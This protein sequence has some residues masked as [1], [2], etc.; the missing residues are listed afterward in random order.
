MRYL[1]EGIVFLGLISIAVG[2]V[3]VVILR[4]ARNLWRRRR[5][6]QRSNDP[7]VVREHSDGMNTELWLEHPIEKAIYIDEVSALLPTWEHQERLSELRIVAQQKAD[8]KNRK[9]LN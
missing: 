8:D 3:W 2:F 5:L 9:L 7:W 1:A 6:G 4:P